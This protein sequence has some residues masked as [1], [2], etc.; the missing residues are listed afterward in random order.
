MKADRD[1]KYSNIQVF[2]KEI[3]SSDHL[4]QIYE[5]DKVFLNSLE[6][7]AGSAFIAG[8]SVIVIATAEH[9]RA[10]EKLLK[11]HDFDINALIADRQYIPLNA[12]ETLAKFMVD[13]KPDEF[14]FEQLATRL[15]EDARKNNRKVRAFGEM[16]ALLWA[17]GNYEA[18]IQLEHLWNK[19]HAKEAFSLFC[20]YPKSGFNRGFIEDPNVSIMDIC[21]THTKVIG[22]WDKSSTE[23]FYKSVD[24]LPGQK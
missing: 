24:T 17:E 8:E 11:A 21:T 1:W 12:V 3:A 22:G 4:V 18:T 7:F 9:L 19:M 2:W 16:V 5:N 10:L 13:G 20:A 23:I 14:L 15:L 6:G